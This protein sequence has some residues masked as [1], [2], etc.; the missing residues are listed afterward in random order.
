M[1]LARL[2]A[3][4][5]LPRHPA[6]DDAP[7]SPRAPFRISRPRWN[8]PQA[9]RTSEHAELRPCLRKA[10]SAPPALN[11]RGAVGAPHARAIEMSPKKS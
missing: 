3:A 5:L 7:E 4:P 1:T 8:S 10:T 6:A 9:G 11:P 2:S